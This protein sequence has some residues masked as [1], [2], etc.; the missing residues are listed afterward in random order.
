MNDFMCSYPSRL[1]KFYGFK[2][3]WRSTSTKTPMS[4]G[5]MGEVLCRGVQNYSCLFE[6]SCTSA[7]RKLGQPMHSQSANFFYTTLLGG[8]AATCSDGVV[9]C[10]LKVLLACLGSMAAAVQ[11]NSLGTLRKHFT[12]PLEQVASPPSIHTQGN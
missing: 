4:E 8:G 11:P 12:K 3:S 10:F 1:W 7:A 6:S 9:I 2:Q 5:E